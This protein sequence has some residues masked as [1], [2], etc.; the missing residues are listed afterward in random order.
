[1]SETGSV[2]FT[3]EQAG[4]AAAEFT[5]LA[6]LNDYRSR[7][8]RLGL[9]GADVAGIGFGNVSV[10]DSTSDQ[11]FITGSGTGC[12]TELEL[13][14]MAKVL[15]FDFARNWLRWQGATVPSSESLTH[16][17]VYIS[18][19]SAGAVIHCHSSKIWS[20]LRAENLAT[21]AAVDYGT[22]AMAE[23]VANL[24][25][26]TA[27]AERKAFA[28]TGHEDGVIGFGRNLDEAFWILMQI[29]AEADAG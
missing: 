2:K 27:A 6:E 18:A 7:L 25:Q 22:P 3:A 13:S 11:F 28:M 26:T 21:P 5:G 1:M 15:E 12:K 20:T 16:A 23:A 9:I 24:L 19:R 17:A 4:P 29:A 8:W 14:D 10:R